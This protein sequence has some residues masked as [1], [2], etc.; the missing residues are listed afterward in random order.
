MVAR[1]SFRCFELTHA[2]DL[3][4]RTSAKYSS[5]K[6]MKVVHHQQ[7]SKQVKPCKY[8]LCKI[9]C[10]PCVS[11]CSNTSGAEKKKKQRTNEKRVLNSN[12]KKRSCRIS[13]LVYRAVLHKKKMK[14]E[15]RERR[16][17]M[18][19]LILSQTGNSLSR[20][21]NKQRR[22]A[23]QHDWPVNGRRRYKAAL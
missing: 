11:V 17:K 3:M 5:C 4:A 18:Q 14:K 22:T 8:G 16:K 2:S 10:Q 13:P 6:I 21:G 23:V 1:D 19:S 20:P 9:V 7:M 15:N 12:S